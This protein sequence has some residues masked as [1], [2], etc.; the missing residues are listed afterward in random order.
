MLQKVGRLV[1]QAGFVS[2]AVLAIGR[3]A[4]LPDA[5]ANQS[6]LA[7]ISQQLERLQSECQERLSSSPVIRTS[8][9]QNAVSRTNLS[10]HVFM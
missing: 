9:S 7:T 5:A 4:D 3:V 1:P 6:R 8:R 2:G 10:V